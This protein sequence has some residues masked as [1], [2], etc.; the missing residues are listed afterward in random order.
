MNQH[1]NAMTYCNETQQ[2]KFKTILQP[3]LIQN[4][5]LWIDIIM[6]VL[7][8]LNGVCFDYVGSK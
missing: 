2:N 7:L 5:D 8:Y 6:M 4:N 3:V 1:I